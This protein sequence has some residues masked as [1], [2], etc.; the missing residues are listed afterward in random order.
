MGQYENYFV[1]SG[2]PKELTQE[3]IETSYNAPDFF[4]DIEINDTPETKV[5]QVIQEVYRGAKGSVAGVRKF[6]DTFN[7]FRGNVLMATG[8]ETVGKRLVKTARDN[9]NRIQRD[10]DLNVIGMNDERR[11]SFASALGSAIPDFAAQIGLAVL[12]GPTVA[13][14]TMAGKEYV[15]ELA[16]R[17]MKEDETY[18]MQKARENLVSSGLYAAGSAYLERRLGLEPLVNRIFKGKRPLKAAMKG[19]VAEGGTEFLQGN[20]STVLQLKDGYV[21]WD[22]MPEEIKQNVVE[23]AIG[24]ILGGTA[25]FSFSLRNRAVLAKK[26]KERYG[27]AWG[28]KAEETSFKVS[29]ALLDEASAQVVNELAVTSE[30]QNYHGDLYSKLY[31]EVGKL[32]KDIPFESDLDRQEYLSAVS[33]SVADWTVSEALKRN[34]PVEDVLDVANVFMSKKGLRLKGLTEYE[35][36]MDK[37]DFENFLAKGDRDFQKLVDESLEKA[38]TEYEGL[39]GKA[40]EAINSEIETLYKNVKSYISSSEK[41]YSRKQKHASD[42]VKAFMSK[43]GYKGI[44][45]MVPDKNTGKIT[46][47]T[48]E[49]FSK[50]KNWGARKGKVVSYDTIIEHLVERGILSEGATQNDLIDVLYNDPVI[51]GKEKFK[52]EEM[53][54]QMDDLIRLAKIVDSDSE[55]VIKEKIKNY[56]L[57]EGSGVSKI[58][59]IAK[60][61]LPNEDAYNVYEY[62]KTEGSTPL[63]AYEIAI[64]EAYAEQYGFY[65]DLLNQSDE[66]VFA[67]K[68]TMD[69]MRSLGAIYHATMYDDYFT[70][71]NGR[72]IRLSMHDA[73]NTRSSINV[74]YGS[75]KDGI[76]TNISEEK[77]NEINALPEVEYKKNY[78]NLIPVGDFKGLDL[79][80]LSNGQI[81]TEIATATSDYTDL[82]VEAYKR[83]IIDKETYEKPFLK[84]L[85]EAKEGLK[86]AKRKRKD[87]EE[88]ESF[89]QKRIDKYEALL[90]PENLGTENGSV[91]YQE[92]FDVA[93]ENAETEKADINSQEFKEW[94]N[95]APFYE[96]NKAA[97][98]NFKTG[99][100]L[101]AEVFHGTQ[102]ADRVGD[103]FLPSR[104][105]SGPMAFST[106]TRFIAENYAKDKNDTSIYNET[107]GDFYK[108]YTVKIPNHDPV[109][110]DRLWNILPY[111]KKKEVREKAPHITLD[112]EGENV[113]Y[114][115]KETRGNGGYYIEGNQNPITALVE[116]WPNAGYFFDEME[117]FQKVLELAGLDEYEIKYIDP[118][119]SYPKVYELYVEM[120][121]PLVTH[122]IPKKVVAALKREAKK[123]PRKT[124]NF[125]ADPW[126]KS[127]KD[128][129]EWI[130]GLDE[131]DTYVWTSIPDWVTDTLK[132]MGY[133]GIVDAGG[134]EGGYGHNVFIPFESQ[135]Y[136]SVYN[137]G[138]FSK[139]N[140]SIYFQDIKGKFNKSTRI[141]TLTKKADYSTLPHEFAHY[142]L[143]DALDYANSGLASDEYV[144]SLKQT[145]KDFN[146]RI[147]DGVSATKA[148]HEF[149][150]RQYERYLYENKADNE[151]VKQVFDTYEKFLKKCYNNANIPGS[152]P[153]SDAQVKFFNDHIRGEIPAP[154][155]APVSVDELRRE[156]ELSLNAVPDQNIETETEV[157]K[158]YV[159]PEAETDEG[160]KVSSVYAKTLDVL[161]RSAVKYGVLHNEEQANIA[162]SI[163]EEDAENARKMI[164][165]EIPMPEGLLRTS[166]MIAYEN[167]IKD[168]DFAEYNRVRRKHSL[169]QTRRGQEI[170]AEKLGE[171]EITDVGLW[172]NG[173]E[174]IRAETAAK[175]FK[176]LL[177][178]SDYQKS[179]KK[180]LYEYI[181]RKAKE[182][183][184]QIENGTTLSEVAKKIEKELGTFYQAETADQMLLKQSYDN[185]YDAIVSIYDDLMNLKVSDAEAE[186]LNNKIDNLKSY[187]SVVDLSKDIPVEAWQALKEVKDAYNALNPSSNLSLMT[188]TVGRGAMLSAPSTYVLNIVSNAE[189][190]LAEKA[191]RRIKYGTNDSYV[192]ESLKDK[193]NK[194][195][196]EAYNIS[197]ITLSTA[198]PKEVLKPAYQGESVISSAGEGKIREAARF[199]EKWVFK[200]GLGYPDMMFKNAAFVDTVD[201][202]ASKYAK[203]KAKTEAERRKIA[204]EI[205]NDATKIE[206]KTDVGKEVREQAVQEALTITFTNNSKISQ[207]S[208]GIRNAINKASGD[209]MIGDIIM[210]FVKTPANVASLGLQY[211]VG[212]AYTVLNV[213]TIAQ[214]IRNGQMSETSRN[215]ISAA[216]R[217]GLGMAL[218]LAVGSLLDEEDYIPPYEASTMKDREMARL[219]NA[220]YNSIRFGNTYVSLDYFGAFA[221]PLVGVLMAKRDE[222]ISSYFKGVS[223]QV[224]QIPG[225]SELSSI[226]KNIETAAKDSQQA[227][228]DLK[229][230][231]VDAIVARI[232]P[233][234]VTVVE[235]MIDSYFRETR[236]SRIYSRVA[237]F[238][239]PEKQFVAEEGS[240][241]KNLQDRILL[242]LTG[243]RAK[244]AIDNDL[245]EELTRLNNTGNGVA[246]TEVTRNAAFKDLP[247]EKRNEIQRMFIQGFGSQEGYTDQVNRLIK[248][249]RYKRMDDSDKKKEINKIR[250]KI[251]NK[252]K[253]I[254]VSDKMAEK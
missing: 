233:N 25:S 227:A 221:A 211:A 182:Y 190:N 131:N 110:L 179:P 242:F 252:L 15:G 245:T 22:E 172:L 132:K 46:L 218:A 12:S 52:T 97:E 58:D 165:G 91:L 75:S 151:A 208:L 187:L 16:D 83:G 47:Q 106:D 27:D 196:A 17:S 229:D 156:E 11:S 149:F 36:A 224:R 127:T 214:D 135:Q 126:D 142:F 170:Q 94:S 141:I 223:Y 251:I 92:S 164:D 73:F 176:N 49:E 70:L 209:A 205:F 155:V 63:D 102:R 166:L 232:V 213:R 157:K 240:R 246:L 100:P 192:S 203:T 78:R 237:P 134:K 171:T 139:F 112:D 235:N 144:E 177:K 71:R 48:T 121:N 40:K 57:S 119:A 67:D 6:S 101:V 175:K 45:D 124:S 19:F 87:R 39:K 99:E 145:L 220:P 243:S 88:Y 249:S 216:M 248:T 241:R 219:K 29:N 56:L 30:M 234:A 180:A 105:T 85:E 147:K 226:E 23:G 239:L 90:S 120:Q 125:G 152:A 228:Q 184:K 231:T 136:K 14:T 8:N 123:Q 61:T 3:D 72:R 188:S 198:T 111:E 138:N 10:I 96:A 212:S 104:A 98:H 115:E 129:I 65:E 236:E 2:F 108:Y 210:P 197:G 35:K 53:A 225:I 28:D 247:I 194:M 79:S 183:V 62:W 54:E 74:E 191:V 148:T 84:Q 122:D 159:Y 82:W 202:L 32:I 7:L 189:T 89:F 9:L 43:N 80:S 37:L 38:K 20:L 114:N 253:K 77:I 130:N 34:I 207:F 195:A 154:V 60:E 186:A 33:K 185:A 31:D 116:A 254:F 160:G 26:L 181:D 55:Q 193:Y 146:G 158:E 230:A 1:G 21:D 18:D 41:V 199:V 107:E 222:N 206:P 137:K 244:R 93:D 168:I 76:K 143:Q 4:Q 109:T 69:I 103:T 178:K 59:E 153:L 140:P 117:K 200:Y 64:K 44:G 150:A 162:S 163:V 86:S 133:D 13:I 50:Q 128:P 161:N 174:D 51:E 215:A 24:G 118:Y 169:E 204:D 201:L 113:I 81:K 68:K 95:N 217:N 5:G 173:A 42:V 238:M 167:Y 66:G 250:S